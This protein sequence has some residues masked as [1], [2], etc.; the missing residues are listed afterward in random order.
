MLNIRPGGNHTTQHHEPEAEQGHARH[1][2]AEPQHL[3]VRDEDDGQVLE[4]GVDG[5]A[6][7]L[8]GFEGGVDHADEEE[9]DGE[10]FARFV[11]IEIAVFDEAH[12]FAGGD[13]EDAHGVL[14]IHLHQ[15]SQGNSRYLR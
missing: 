13:G 5:D 12:G 1:A 14:G 3:A 8:Q 10:P 15:P 6:E 4:D 11:R 9:G 2:A 7:V